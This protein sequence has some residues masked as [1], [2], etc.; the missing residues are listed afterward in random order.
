[1]EGGERRVEMGVGSGRDDKGDG[2]VEKL[3]KEE[4]KDVGGG[5]K[6]GV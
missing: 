6:K 1:M 3:G 5:R 2:W 4:T